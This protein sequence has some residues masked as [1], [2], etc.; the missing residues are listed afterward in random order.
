[1]R[2]V[3]ATLAILLL[4]LTTLSAHAEPITFRATQD[5]VRVDGSNTLSVS[6]NL[7]NPSEH[8]VYPDS[9][10]LES[11]DQDPGESPLPRRCVTSLES[12]VKMW[13]AADAGSASLATALLGQA[14][15]LT[16][17]QLLAPANGQV[18]KL[19]AGH[20]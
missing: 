17:R 7:L 10:T 13:L 8:G 3:P 12:L 16:H 9:L 1:M 4:S 11:V 14:S 2:S 19:P 18:G 15:A 6:F 20:Q 5:T